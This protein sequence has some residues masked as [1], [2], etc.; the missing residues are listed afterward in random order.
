MSHTHYTERFNPQQAYN[1]VGIGNQFTPVVLPAD[2]TPSSL[3][4]QIGFAQPRDLFVRC[5]SIQ[6]HLVFVAW[7]CV[8]PARSIQRAYRRQPRDTIRPKFHDPMGCLGLQALGWRLCLLVGG[9]G[10]ESE[11]VP[12]RPSLFTQRRFGV[13]GACAAH[14]KKLG[15]KQTLARWRF[16]A[17]RAVSDQQ[18]LQR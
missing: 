15:F 9:S 17:H 7:A 16:G 1:L 3:N 8:K 5:D 13:A 2:P 11:V 6:R 10:V 14:R 4:T 12:N 18:A